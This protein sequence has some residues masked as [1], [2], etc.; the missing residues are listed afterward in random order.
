MSTGLRH[1]LYMLKPQ[2]YLFDSSEALNDKS[3]KRQIQES[4]RLEIPLFPYHIRKNKKRLRIYPQSSSSWPTTCARVIPS[5][6]GFHAK[7]I[8]CLCG[9]SE[10]G[11]NY[12]VWL[13][14][15]WRLAKLVNNFWRS[16]LERFLCN[17]AFRII[18]G[19]LWD[20]CWLCM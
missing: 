6:L 13:G 3:M 2:W 18:I 10:P 5:D 14:C 12:D 7:G 1:E 16:A 20:R 19:W 8:R 11:T 17:R 4:D 9:S 15:P